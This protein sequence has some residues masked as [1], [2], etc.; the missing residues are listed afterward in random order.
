MATG[1][2]TFIINLPIVVQ[3]AIFYTNTANYTPLLLNLS[4]DILFL[5]ML[6]L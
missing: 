4:I 5:Q 6:V 3:K 2:L 1:T